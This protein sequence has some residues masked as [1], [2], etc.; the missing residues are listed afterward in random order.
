MEVEC[1]GE[2]YRGRVNLL[3][4]IGFDDGAEGCVKG[5]LHAMHPAV[6]CAVFFFF[7]FLSFVYQSQIKGRIVLVA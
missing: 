4:M 1:V 2:D 5:D 6:I 3:L 7:F